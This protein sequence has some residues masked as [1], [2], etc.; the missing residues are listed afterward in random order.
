MEKFKNAFTMIELI[1]VIVVLG[2]LAAVA[3]PRLAV[4][5]TDAHISK[6]RSDIAAIRSSIITERQSRLFRGDNTFIATL[7]TGGNALFGGLPAAVPP[8]ILLQYPLTPGVGNG[9]WQTAGTGLS[10][11]YRVSNTAVTF[12]YVP[13]TGVFDCVANAGSV[14]YCAKLTD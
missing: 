13:A 9:H 6:G 12:T 14:D 8:R 5:R 2:I 4:T 10:Y 7:D 3:I 1:F 11:T